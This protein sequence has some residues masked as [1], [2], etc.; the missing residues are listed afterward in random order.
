MK[1]NYF[2]FKQLKDDKYL[3]TTDFGTFCSVNDEEFTQLT[4]KT[5]ERDCLKY[6]ELADKGFIYEN[7]DD[8][9][10][11]FTYLLRRSKSCLFSATT[12]FIFVATTKCNG[13]CM[14]CQAKTSYS[15]AFDMDIKTADKFINILLECPS[16]YINVE[17]QG[18]EPLLNFNIIK[19]IVNTI[20]QSN[21]KKEIRF[22]L[23]SNLTLLNNEMIYFIKNNNIGISSSLDGDLI[24]HDYNRPMKDTTSMYERTKNGAKKLEN[25]NIKVGFIQTTTKFSLNKYKE[26]I[27]EYVSNNSSSIFIRP[28]T[29][30]GM[31]KERWNKIGYTPKEF[32]DFYNSCLD[33]IIDI[34]LK[35]YTLKENL[36]AIFLEMILNNKDT[37][38]MEL[39]SPCGASIGQMAFY[40]TGDIFSCDEGRML[41]EAGDG[42]FKIGEMN[43]SYSELVNN[44]KCK[45]ISSVSLLESLPE[46]ISCVYS[47]YCGV[48]PVV[49]YALYKDLFPNLPNHY[50]CQINKGILDKLFD[51]LLSED[52]DR[53]NVLYN[54]VNYEKE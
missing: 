12:L 49:N 13:D 45:S 40:P 15:N 1:I 18:G 8:F 38:Y 11:D 33:Y 41:Y 42:I 9:L 35:G 22:S 14:Y 31:A 47:P 21:T 17:F 29:P 52:S 7:E 44:S 30:V 10:S 43:N 51:I 20:N 53:M 24:V 23:V 2:N 19:H 16:E 36:A 46:C 50:K 26:I 54:W 25:N 32:I 3:L 39:R 6:K 27:D 28:L 37:N 48:C 34:N 5:I 4:N